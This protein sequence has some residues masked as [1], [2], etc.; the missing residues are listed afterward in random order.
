MKILAA[1]AYLDT[2][3]SV[4]PEAALFAGLVA[5]GHEV[6]MATRGHASHLAWL[7][8]AGVRILDAYPQRKLCPATMRAYRRELRSGG[9]DIAYGMN[10]KTITNLAFA[11]TGL[12]TRL[13]TYRGSSSGM[14][15]H[16]PTSYLTHL[17]PR[18]DAIC[19]V[20]RAVERMV[21]QRVWRRAVVITT[22]HKG[23]ELSWFPSATADLGEFG[24]PAGAFVIACIANARPGKGI[25]LLLAAAGEVLA[26]PEVHLLL[27]GRGMSAAPYAGM[28]EASR[29][30]ERIHLVEHRSNAADLL[31]G[32]SLYVQPSRRGEGLPK[33]VIEAMAQSIPAV[34]SDAGGMPELVVH[35]ESGWVV[36]SGSVPALSSA[37]QH[38]WRQRES[39]PAMGRLARARI[40]SG[41]STR[42]T[43]DG[44]IRLFESLLG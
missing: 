41:F 23:H 7:A 21:R 15:R 19:C 40:G 30:K 10:S 31:A 27:V 33:T 29:W 12:P 44:H 6:T 14:Y 42:R 39:L 3:T 43:I 36:E 37:L 1:S 38:A 16:D 20:S 13:V 4:R 34:V 2:W 28:R 24:I 17:H 25:D 8:A 11:M 22:V 5:R 9:Y 32:A 26:H 18:V 35:G